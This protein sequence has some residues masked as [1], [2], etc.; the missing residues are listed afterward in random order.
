[1][2][3]K[4][5]IYI[6]L[7]T[8][9]R[10]LDSH[11]LLSLFLINH[12]FRVYI[13]NL[14]TLKKL[15][16]KKKNKE[17]IFITKGGLP[18]EDCILIK[19][20]CE[21]YVVID[22]ELSYGLGKESYKS[23]IK[24]RYS[25]NIVKYIDKFYC[26]NKE[27][28]DISSKIYFKNLA[29]A[30][31][32]PRNDLINSEFIPLYKNEV[33]FLKKKYK[34]F[35]LFNSDFGTGIFPLHK[36]KL[37]YHSFYKNFPNFQNLLTKQYSNNF[38]FTDFMNF[39]NFLF[40]LKD[41][42]NLPNIVF[43]PHPS[44][45]IEIWKEICNIS[46]KFY[47]EL[48]KYNVSSIILASNGVLHRGCTTA[49]NAIIYKKKN[50]Y[51]DLTT[52]TNKNNFGFRKA[53]HSNSYKI[54]C[55]KDFFYWL[56][57]THNLSKMSHKFK[58]MLN[59]KNK[60]AS[61]YIANDLNLLKVTDSEGHKNI[62][63]LNFFERNY[64]FLKNKIYNFLIFIKLKKERNLFALGITNKINQNF[65]RLYLQNR[66]NL[67]NRLLIK[68]FSFNKITEYRVRKISNHLFELD[69]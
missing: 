4:K 36:I 20:K 3:L 47:I 6:H 53:L 65:N 38:Y 40:K 30:S 32:W 58:N 69:C 55:A 37:L 44:E 63:L 39:K 50:A 7:E 35:I 22:Q 27:I 14:F 13:G 66:I 43:R 68:S 42:K 54:K 48:P 11:L 25:N 31:G 34:K 49:Y 61:E 41:L 57:K 59:M 45:Q 60:Y 26:L 64:L 12:N 24:S 2:R 51:L 21:F 18:L 15:I 28:A 1:M 10:E 56:K 17:G 8:Q 62:I 16:Q 9:V 52:K 19:R 5:N 23:M 67:I 33:I 29:M 46:N